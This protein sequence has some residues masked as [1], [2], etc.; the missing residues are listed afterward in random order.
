MVFK[1]AITNV[2]LGIQKL[3]NIA[4]K[5][6]EE[7]DWIVTHSANLRIIEA[8]CNELK[9]PEAKTLKSIREYG[10]TSSASI[11][12]SLDKGLKEGKLKKGYT[13][14]LYGFGGGLTQAG[15]LLKWN[16]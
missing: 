6:L 8:V 15:L 4:G 13:I 1:W 7:I 16:I 14:I 11:P 10:N 12:L 3:L 9:F 5:T 2:P